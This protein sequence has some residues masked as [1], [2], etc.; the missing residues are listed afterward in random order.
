M[1]SGTWGEFNCP[2]LKGN[3]SR[4]QCD[5]N[6]EEARRREKERV[7]LGHLHHCLGCAGITHEVEHLTPAPPPYT[8]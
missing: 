5:I 3:I 4:R 8:T 1:S 2:S 6:R 7:W